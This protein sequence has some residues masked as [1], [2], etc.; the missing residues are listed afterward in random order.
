MQEQLTDVETEALDVLDRLKEQTVEKLQQYEQQINEAQAVGEET[1]QLHSLRHKARLRLNKIEE[2]KD[3]RNHM[4][5][6]R[7]DKEGD[8]SWMYK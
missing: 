8:Q 2:L 3:I 6:D 1:R 5:Q 7:L 4:I